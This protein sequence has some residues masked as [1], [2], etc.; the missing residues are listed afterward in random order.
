MFAGDVALWVPIAS[1]ISGIVITVI[2]LRFGEAN[3]PVRTHIV[4][5]LGLAFLVPLILT[6][7]VYER[8]PGE[9]ITGILGTVV[10]YFFGAGASRQGKG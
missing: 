2:A 4:E 6:L 8:I 7:G 10:G 1:L 9:A 3:N 5:I